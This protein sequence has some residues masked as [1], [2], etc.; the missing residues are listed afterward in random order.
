MKK[1]ERVVLIPS[2][3]NLKSR[4]DTILMEEQGQGGRAHQLLRTEAYNFK[5]KL[6]IARG[7]SSF[8]TSNS[9]KL[10]VANSFIKIPLGI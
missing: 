9:K 4:Q 7:L 5:L 10:L 2:R 3:G 6:S 8:K 1:R